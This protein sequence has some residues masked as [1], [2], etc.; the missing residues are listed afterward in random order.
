MPKPSQSTREPPSL[1]P[2]QGSPVPQLPDQQDPVV[3]ESF[4][5]HY[6]FPAG[7]TPLPGTTPTC[8]TAAITTQPL[9][10]S[11][12][13]ACPH[14][15]FTGGMVQLLCLHCEEE[16]PTARCADT[17]QAEPN[18]ASRKTLPLWSASPREMV[19]PSLSQLPT[20]GHSIRPLRDEAP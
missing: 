7:Q 12:F 5:L 18:A 9:S 10:P 11:A 17:S 14:S 4:L 8:D 20:P 1:V 13:S 3:P 2:H 15:G 19:V 16:M 6:K